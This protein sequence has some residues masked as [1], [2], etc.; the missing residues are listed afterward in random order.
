MFEHFF[1]LTVG[2]DQS[3]SAGAQ[4][5]LRFHR[6]NATE[7]SDTVQAW[8]EVQSVLPNAVA[9]AGWDYKTLV[10]TGAEASSRLPAPDVPRLE[11]HDAARPYRFES[12]EAARLR[13]DLALAAYE[14]T[15]R[16]FGGASTVRQLA[17][18]TV[19]SLSQHGSYLGD[20]ARFSIV[21]VDHHGANNLGAQ[22]AALLGLAEAEA[23]SYRNTCFA[24][25]AALPQVPRLLPKPPARPQV[26]L[27]VGLPDCVLTT[28]RDHRIKIQFP[29]Q[30][31]A[32]PAVGGLAESGPAGR[33]AGK[34][35]NAPGNDQSGTWVRV[36]EWQ[37]GPNW[38]SHFLPRIG[39]EVLV[40][41]LD[42]DIDRP[43]I[44]GQSYNGAD[45][46]PFS[47]GHEASANH[48]GVLSGWMSHNHEAGFN[49]WVIDDAPGQLRSRLAS[50]ENASQLSL[51]H[52]IHQAPDSA[53]RGAWR[54]SGFELR[55]D[56]WLAVR[57]GEGLLISATARADGQST[58]MDVAEAVSQ[59]HAAEDT[60]KALSDAASQQQALPLQANS[61]LTELIATVDP[62]KDGKFE[63][64][65]GGQAAKKANP[66]SRELGE[67]TEHFAKPVLVTEAPSD[68]GLASPASTLLFAG[69]HL[70]ATSQQDLH[71]ASAH[72]LAA[73]VGKGAS[74]FSHAGGIKSIAQ[75]GSQTI[76]ANTDAME[77][78]ADQSITV[79]SSNDEIH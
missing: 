45:L 58:Q 19:I 3:A 6:A 55:T 34:T 40:D 22:A 49:Q 25:P 31:G 54:G 61:A 50:S 2:L 77:I 72:T 20:E 69:R 24:Q 75:A 51:G 60:A 62:K 36:A 17:E 38:G 57:A 79:T 12:D 1:R 10:A 7:A 37:A 5:M 16:R 71:L 56:G 47:A 67:P 32:A 70:H 9:L 8:H 15:Y 65:V 46:P 41:F 76:Q 13:T 66:G 48:P 74:W 11:I 27:V 64:A 43:V 53:T 18:G 52:L 21:S 30:R 44:V 63:S 59:L 78:L 26:A 14:G 35:G 68:I 4:P 29:W 39:T 28:E 23:G 42:G 73:A 33:N